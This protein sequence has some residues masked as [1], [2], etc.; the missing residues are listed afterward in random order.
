VPH[1]TGVRH[2]AVVPYAPLLLAIASARM[3]SAIPLVPR[4]IRLLTQLISET[5][6]LSL[7]D[8]LTLAEGSPRLER[9]GEMQAAVTEFHQ[10]LGQFRLNQVPIESLL[11]HPVA[12]ALEGFFR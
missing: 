7:E 12:Q 4:L 6:G 8:T 9:D 3:D 1:V 11:G 5:N 2:D 10:R